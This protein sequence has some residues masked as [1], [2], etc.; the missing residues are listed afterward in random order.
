MGSEVL[1]HHNPHF[2]VRAVGAF[3]QKPGCPDY[4]VTALGTNE[5][6]RLCRGEC[7]NPSDERKIITRIEVIRI[8]PQITADESITDLIEDPCFPVSKSTIN[9]SWLVQNSL[10]V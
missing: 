9:P 5:L 4:S 3:K 6:E 7:Y 2:E 10:D 1:M 8:R